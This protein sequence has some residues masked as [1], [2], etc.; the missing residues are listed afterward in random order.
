MPNKKSSNRECWLCKRTEKELEALLEQ[1][2]KPFINV[3]V[4]DKTSITVCV[5]CYRAIQSIPTV[6]PAFQE[7]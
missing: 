1:K 7:E 2:K 5:V 3:S 4:G 6:W